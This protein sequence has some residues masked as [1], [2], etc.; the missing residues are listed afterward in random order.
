MYWDKSGKSWDYFGVPGQPAALLLDKEG[1][2][3]ASW[4]GFLD[5]KEVSA[6]LAKLK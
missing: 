1:N 3:V 6:E 4:T 2:V 5:T